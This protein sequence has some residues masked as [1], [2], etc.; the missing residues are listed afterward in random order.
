[1]KKIIIYVLFVTVLVFILPII[2]TNKFEQVSTKEVEMGIEIEKYDYGNL[3]TV[4]LLHTETGI[5]EDIVLDKYLCGVLAAEIPATY[6]EES[7]KA[8]AIVAR[9]YTIYNIKNV[10]K[11]ENADICDSFLCCQ[12]WMTKENR[13]ARWEDGKQNEYWNKILNAVNSTKGKYITY[14]GEPINALFHSNSGGS[15]ELP[16]N[17]WGGD[18]PYLQVIQT[19]G[20]DAYSSYS[21]E[22]EISKDELVQKMLER[23]SSF[24]INF[25]APD[26][27]KILDLNESGRVRN[28]QIGNVSIS[29]IDARNMFGLKSANFKFE[30]VDNTVKF[31]V[32]GYGHGVG[33]SQSGSD[34]LAKNGMKYDEIIK[35]YYKNVEISE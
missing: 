15:T 17:V 22:V 35:H 25:S 9:T 30:I 23:Y 3:S 16:V 7:L 24:K 27:I 33:L 19:S 28:V 2:F 18:Y 11:H 32:I 14:S 10:N 31:S 26:C 5:V 8:Q 13:F 4:K 12:A 20:E 6:N 29:G 21:S 1:M 34:A